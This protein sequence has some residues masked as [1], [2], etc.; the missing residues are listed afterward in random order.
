[1]ARFWLIFVFAI[2]P[3][4]LELAMALEF[5]ESIIAVVAERKIQEAMAEG[6]FDNLPG[7]GQPQ[8]LEDLTGIPEDL[9]LSYIIIKNA[10]YVDPNSAQAG[11]F[12]SLLAA[13]PEEAEYFRRLTKL[14]LRLRSRSKRKAVDRL[15]DSTYLSQILQ[16]I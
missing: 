8:N 5:S 7:E 2:N 10:G 12:G 9:R 15:T 13:A 11:T 4:P 14:N 16:K 1:M 3:T 6:Q